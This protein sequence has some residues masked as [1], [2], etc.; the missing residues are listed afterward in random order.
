LQD[1][2]L[3]A[4]YYEYRIFETVLFILKFIVKKLNY[5]LKNSKNMLE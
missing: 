3:Y 1:T 5:L 2:K 4:K